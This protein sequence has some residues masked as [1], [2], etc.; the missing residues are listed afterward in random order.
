MKNR[1][2]LPRLAS[3]YQ[4]RLR[5]FLSTLLVASVRV[6]RHERIYRNLGND[7]ELSRIQPLGPEIILVLYVNVE[8]TLLVLEIPAERIEFFLLKFHNC[9]WFVVMMMMMTTYIF[10]VKGIVNCETQYRNKGW[11]AQKA[12]ALLFQ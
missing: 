8:K 1:E 2:V 12:F 6:Q 11:L 7:A 4:P 9:L 5:S 3:Y 10:T